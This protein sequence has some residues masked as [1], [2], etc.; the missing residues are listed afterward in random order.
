MSSPVL[1]LIDGSSYIFRAYFA[2]RNL[3]TSKGFP[4]NAVYGFSSMLFRF[5]KDFD[6]E[7]IAIVFDSK[8]KNFRNDIFPEYKANREEPPEDL[9]PQIEKI[10]EMV[11]AFS[12]PLVIRQG[13]E[14]DDLIGTIAMENAGKGIEVVIITGDKDFCQLVS[15]NI[16]LFDTMKNT[17]TGIKEVKN[18]YGVLPEKLIDLMALC[19]DKIDNIPGVRGIGEKTASKLI[20]EYGSLENIY[21]NTENLSGR[22]KLMLEEHRKDAFMSKE[23]V[24]IK[25]D[26][27]V[28]T[29]LK[30]YHYNGFDKE[31]LSQLFDELEFQNLLKELETKEQRKN[32]D[33]EKIHK[34]GEVSYKLITSE[35]E[36]EKIIGDIREK[37]LVSVDLETTSHLPM[38][39]EIVG[40]AISLEEDSGFYIPVG[41]KTDGSFE[42]LDRELVLQM[43][44][45]ILESKNI[46]KIGQ[47]LKYEFIVFH[48]CGIELKGI[49]FDTMLA[50]HL[51]DSSRI[52]YKLDDLSR[53]YLSHK[54]VSYKEVTGTGKSKIGF[55]EVK[56]DK[57]KYYACEDSDITLK[58]FHQLSVELDN[59][60]LKD[61]YHSNV[62]NIV[63]VL[64]E[65]ELNGVRLDLDVLKKL[66]DS[67]K[68]E[69]DKVSNEVYSIVGYEFNLNS[70]LQL[71][72]VLFKDLNL[73]VK[74]KTRTGEPSTD[75]EVL[76]DLCKYH[77]VPDMVLKQRALSKL[78]STY[79]DALPKLVN[80]KTHRLHTSYNPVGTST[81]RLS[82]SD[83]NLQNIPVKSEEGRMIRSAFITE[84]GYT[85]LCADYSQIELRLLAHFSEDESL[86]RAFEEDKDIHSKTATEIF[87]VQEDDVTPEMRRLSKSI[88]F[89]IIY[90][91]SPFG[92]A[93][94]LGTSVSISKDYID[95]YFTRYERVKSYLDKSIYE[96]QN[97][98]YAETLIGRR[99]PIPELNSRN[100]IQRGIGE[101]AAINT[102]IQGSAADIINLAMIN[103][104]GKVKNCRSK[105]IM[106]VH[107]ELI[108]EISNDEIEELKSMIKQEMEHAFELKVA[109]KVDI[110]T[111]NN[112]AEVN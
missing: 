70:P 102:P 80:P 57:A 14:A 47:N 37:G 89:G 90:G 82:S 84:E 105:M 99:R 68:K 67:F 109:L 61:V 110:K 63:K 55:D 30:K 86:I 25:T 13:F 48:N 72:D 29:D 33:S 66:S 95:K 93:R 104:H 98:G 20:Q 91:I 59:A 51:I 69:I 60:G 94:Q 32:P 34:K 45:D 96:A 43:L 92:L 21:E 18:R 87:R 108:F 6:P 111:G 12:I 83:P 39:A 40:I 22:Q 36:L 31:R 103:I 19:G 5:I 23:L 1:Y 28:E 9:I 17:R 35:K 44:K 11:S 53:I 42:Q 78:V 75:Y 100:R 26:V 81:G 52:S 46:K 97:N 54:M 79:I 62:I 24:T 77:T 74:K 41:H 16:K 71:R 49:H 65:I 27:N 106:Q 112:W 56:I 85:L 15:E 4:T 50:A 64:A 2:I 10:H 38:N 101:R 7:Y 107:D 73:P 58:L 3:T 88:N 76:V 8:G